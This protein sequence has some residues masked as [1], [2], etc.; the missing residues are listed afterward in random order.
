MRYLEMSENWPF[1]CTEILSTVENE[2]HKKVKEG[3]RIFEGIYLKKFLRERIPRSDKI[4]VGC[5]GLQL[6][7]K[8]K[9]IRG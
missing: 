8:L 3:E 1:L 4:R 9:A 5:Q 2:N 6:F 7:K